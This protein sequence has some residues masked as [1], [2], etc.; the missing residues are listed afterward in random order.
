M[1]KKTLRLIVKTIIADQETILLDGLEL[2]LTSGE[3]YFYRVIARCTSSQELLQKV[4]ENE[5]D[6]IITDINLGDNESSAFLKDTKSMNSTVHICVLSSYDN[7]KFVRQAFVNGAEA[8]VSKKKGFKD[9]LK[10]IATISNG[11]TYLSEGLKMTPSLN[12]IKTKE[13]NNRNS[14]FLD[15]FQLIETLTKREMEILRLIAD[16]KSNVEIGKKLFISDQTVGVHRKNIMRKLS[17]NS[18]ASLIKFAYENG[19]V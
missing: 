5:C 8:F 2:L 16:A 9:L 19:L 13:D 18:T 7:D 12:K 11:K 14:K 10:G 3:Q 17:V 1:L 15:E 6:L 4:Q